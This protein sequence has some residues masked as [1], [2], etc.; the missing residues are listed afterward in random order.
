MMYEVVGNH[1]VCGHAPGS[2]VDA[3]GFDG[4]D[5]AHLIAAGHIVPV[6]KSKKTTNDGVAVEES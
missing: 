1:S 2:I 6:V 3:D 4:A 5:V